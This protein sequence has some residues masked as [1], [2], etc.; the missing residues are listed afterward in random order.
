[1]HHAWLP[2]VNALANSLG[3]NL[4]Y[5]LYG[6]SINDSTAPMTGMHLI[7]SLPHP[8]MRL[9]ATEEPMAH[10]IRWIKDK[11]QKADM[12]EMHEPSFLISHTRMAR[13]VKSRKAHHMRLVAI[14]ARCGVNRRIGFKG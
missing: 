8:M 13:Q 11:N 3:T 9:P 2:F 7:F 14:C 10:K 5:G 1:M 4:L 6:I 12:P